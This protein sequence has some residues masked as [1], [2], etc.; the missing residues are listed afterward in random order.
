MNERLRRIMREGSQAQ[1]SPQE[2]DDI[3]NLLAN[4]YLEPW[5]RA[6]VERVITPRIE[7]CTASLLSGKL[8]TQREE[9]Q[10]RG[11]VRG[12]ALILVID[13]RG[14]TLAKQKGVIRDGK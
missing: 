6:L 9:D 8:A 13:E 7:N 10:M 12:L 2:N 14:K 4:A 3:D 11:E 5:W 1:L